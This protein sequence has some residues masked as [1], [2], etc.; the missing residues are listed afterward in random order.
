MFE[1]PDALQKNFQ[2]KILINNNDYENEFEKDGYFSN[3]HPD[4]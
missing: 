1:K 4:T 3:A 2:E